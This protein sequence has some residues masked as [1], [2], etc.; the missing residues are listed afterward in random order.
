MEFDD[1]KLGVDAMEELLQCG[2]HTV[3]PFSLMLA[4]VYVYMKRNKKLVSVKAPL[5][6]FTPEELDRHRSIYENFYIPKTVKV[7]SIF[8]TS[9]KVIRSLLQTLSNGSQFAPAIYEVSNEVLLGTFSLWGRDLTVDPF[10][11]AIFTDELC[12]PLDPEKMLKA[13]ETAIIRHESGILISGTLIFILLHLGY[14]NFQIL[15]QIRVEVY[16]VIVAGKEAW[17]ENPQE[18]NLIATDLKR[19]LANKELIRFSSL[20]N[21]SILWQRSLVGRLHRIMKNPS[22]KNYPSLVASKEQGLYA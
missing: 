6:F 22:L 13:R 14:V 8:Q 3:E 18:W 16:D 4:P 21:N 20:N 15:Q 12:G 10:F 19:I 2:I 5:D 17:S 1:K 9:A 11:C 7:G